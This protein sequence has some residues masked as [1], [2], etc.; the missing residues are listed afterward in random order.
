YC[1]RHIGRD[2]WFAY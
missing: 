2:E 1:A